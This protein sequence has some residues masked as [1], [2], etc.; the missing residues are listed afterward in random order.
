MSFL[1]LKIVTPER[2]VFEEG[3]FDSISLPSESGEI[4]IL[5]GHIPLV[6]KVIPGEIVARRGNKEESLVTLNGFLKVNE[7]GEIL[8][9]S[10]YAVRSSEVEIEKAEEAKR[11]AEEAMKEKKSES[12]FVIA[13]ADLRRTLLELKVAQK[14]KVKIRAS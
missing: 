4:T 9:L 2:K 12:E 10:D 6:G 8:I 1:S 5:P 13:E 7:K 3:E 14:R 11:R